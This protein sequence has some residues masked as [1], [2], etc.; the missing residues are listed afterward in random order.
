MKTTLLNV[1]E[2]NLPQL[3]YSVLLKQEKE[4]VYKATVWG[5]EDCQATGE[6][7]EAALTTINQILKT[8]LE[9]TEIIVQKV[10][11]PQ[12]KNPWIKWA[13]MYKDN[14]L[15][16]DMLGEIDKL[17]ERGK[18]H[19]EKLNFALSQSGCPEV[20]SLVDLLDELGFHLAVT[21]KSDN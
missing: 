19:Y 10:A 16:N 18:L 2:G 21:V 17:S 9:N 1:S 7:K 13:G 12:L 6:T 15:F 11:L 5:L 4:G 8:R 3:T 20:Y 14:P